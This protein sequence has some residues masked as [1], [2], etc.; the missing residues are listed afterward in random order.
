V[1]WDV[2]KAKV[3]ARLKGHQTRI[4][5]I[6]ATDRIAASAAGDGSFKLW[7]LGALNLIATFAAHQRDVYSVDIDRGRRKIVSGGFDRKLCFWDVANPQA[8]VQTIEQH[9]AA[10]TSVGFDSSGNMAISGGKDLR[11]SIWDLRSGICV[12]S[13]TPIL[14]EVSSVCADDSF[15]RILAAGKN[16]T[17]RIWD[18]RAAS[19]SLSLKGHQNSSKSFVRAIFGPQER[20][21]IS[22]SDDGRIYCWDAD[23]GILVES[24]EAHDGGAFEVV[25]SG[26]LHKFASCGENDIVRIWEERQME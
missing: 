6:S 25:Y 8:P 19:T 3:V 5:D 4:W 13:L 20:T 23:S 11:V 2:R 10:I 7:D 17:N 12:Q 24:L 16:N 1:I 22:G 15:T 14:A 21:V 26:D 9:K 18:L